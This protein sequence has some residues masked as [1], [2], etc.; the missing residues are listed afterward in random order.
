LVAERFNERTALLAAAALLVLGGA[1]VLRWP[2]RSG[3]ELDL[4]PSQ[5]WP[6]PELALALGASDGPVLV[7]VE[8]RVALQNQPAFY[9]AMSA[10][11]IVRRRDGA[12]RWG[13]FR[14][15]ADLERLLE[16]FVVASWGEH[17]RQHERVTVAD[18]AVEERAQAL[19][20]PGTTPIVAHLISTPAIVGKSKA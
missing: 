13:L 19:Q 17:M 1:T 5:H 20:K 11:E 12:R 18:R 2:L 16:T 6:D 9:Q 4:N 14:D 3:E 15:A 7:T 10:L 8:Y